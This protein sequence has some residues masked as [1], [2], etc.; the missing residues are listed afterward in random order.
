MGILSDPLSSQRLPLRHLYPANWCDES[1]RTKLAYLTDHPELCENGELL[2]ACGGKVVRKIELPPSLGGGTVVHKLYRGKKPWR[3]VLDLSLPAREWRNYQAIYRLGLP[4]PRVLAYGEK[5]RLG[6][7]ES[8]F[9][10]TEFISGTRDGCDFMPRGPRRG[11]VPMRRRFCEL[12]APHLAALHRIGF[13]HKAFHPRNILYRGDTPETME[14]FFVDVA[15]CRIRP[16]RLMK[17]PI[18]FD[19]YTPLRDLALPKEE[20]LEFLAAYLKHSPGCPFDMAQLEKNLRAFRRH[21]EYFD[22]IG[23]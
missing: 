19:L 2:S 16:K 7:L 14:V 4:A 8:S 17:F 21:G 18:L 22:V 3:Y 20:S 11:D 15:R 12:I 13:F 9:I 10:V 6:V 5:R 1:F 23:D